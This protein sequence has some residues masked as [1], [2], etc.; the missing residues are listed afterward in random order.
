MLHHFTLV[1]GFLT[2]HFRL[3]AQG[4]DSI[5]L[6]HNTPGR[7]DLALSVISIFLGMCLSDELQPLRHLVRAGLIK[8]KRG[9]NIQSKVRVQRDFLGQTPDLEACSYRHFSNNFI[10]QLEL[11][12]QYIEWKSFVCL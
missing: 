8:K 2:R 1:C 5:L 10:L 12:H 3:R 4:K 9:K 6:Q 11:S 7:S